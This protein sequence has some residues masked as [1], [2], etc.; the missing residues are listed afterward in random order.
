MPQPGTVLGDILETARE[1]GGKIVKEV[2][3]APIDIVRE[4]FDQPIPNPSAERQQQVKAEDKAK[5]AKIRSGLSMEQEMR[6]AP[7]EQK[8]QQGAEM[9][10]RGQ[11]NQNAQM[12]NQGQPLS[13]SMTPK[14][15]MQ[16]LVLQQKR[17][18]RLQGAA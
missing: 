4:S 15:Q 5:L 11:T 13:S 10:E 3:S 18:D 17:K 1:Q 16:P 9:A 6:T 2:V 12:N 14:K 8:V 7:P